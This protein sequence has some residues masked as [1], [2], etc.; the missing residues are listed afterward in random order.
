MFR[1]RGLRGAIAVELGAVSGDE[2]RG[3]GARVEG[4][5]LWGG[6]GGSVGGIGAAGGSTDDVVLAG[7]GEAFLGVLAAL[8][9]DGFVG[10]R[11]G[12]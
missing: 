5:E 2:M 12:F 3:R 11:G 1:I 8:G 10:L 7:G 6:G 4:W 9:F